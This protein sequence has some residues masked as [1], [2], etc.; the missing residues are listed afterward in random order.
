MGITGLLFSQNI[1]HSIT[2][3]INSWNSSFIQ[4]Y[5]K[6]I[7]RSV[8][9]LSIAIPTSLATYGYFK[10]KEKWIK[11]A[12]FV[13]SSIIE[14]G[15]LSSSLKAVINRTRPYKDNTSIIKRSSVHG[16]SFPSRHTALAFSLA[17]SLSIK[18]PKWYIIAPSALWAT[19]VGIARIN[20]GV[21]YPSDVLSGA[22]IGIGCAFINTYVNKWLNQILF[23]SK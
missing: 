18:Y 6:T 7:S 8:T 11:D 3:Q 21:H 15:L 17:T 12:V 22:V 14:A 10:K 23:K 4:D 9:F 5:S 20:Q 19:S 2:K 1:D 13:G 16:S